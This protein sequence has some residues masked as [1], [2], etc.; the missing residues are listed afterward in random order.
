VGGAFG[1]EVGDLIS[2]AE[3]TWR[4]GRV[5]DDGLVRH[6]Q[7]GAAIAARA[8]PRAL[9]PPELLLIDGPALTRAGLPGPWVA[10]SSDPWPGSISIRA[11]AAQTLVMERARALAPAGIGQVTEPL[12][13]GPL[14][15]WDA[16]NTLDLYMPKQDLS[17]RAEEAVLSGANRLLLSNEA[18]WELLAWQRA[19]LI[20]PDN[21]RLSGLLRGLNGSP[22]ISVLA[23]AYA[24]LADDRLI[25]VDLT[26]EETGLELIWQAGPSEYQAFTYKERSTLPWRVGHL[27]A[28]A[29][30]GDLE[31]SWTARGSEYSNNWG[32]VDALVSTRYRIETRLGGQWQLT[33]E[34]SSTGLTLEAGSAEQ[35]RVAAMSD[36]HR[37]GE[38]VSIPLP[39]A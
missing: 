4:L 18:G 2:Q 31:I 20:G 17:S 9:T 32:A 23:G 36:D 6:A 37:L 19:D 12:Q 22:V 11:G 10:A 5:E 30:G 26:D 33:A 1:L 38:W 8:A 15:R 29:S 25:Q 7:L 16:A 24:V 13:A 14:G 34:Q 3:N 28:I 27:K 39:P 21:W 35:I